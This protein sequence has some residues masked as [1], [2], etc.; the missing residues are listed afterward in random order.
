MAAARPAIA[1]A[2]AQ[3]AFVH[4]SAPRDADRWFAGYGLSD[5]ARV[6]DPDKGLYRRF[7]LHEAP[8]GQLAHPRVWWPWLRTAILGRRGFGLAGPNWRQLTGVF[9]LHQGRVTSAVRHADSAA[10]PDYVA[11]VRGV[12]PDTTIR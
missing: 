7:G 5:I 6:A 3:V 9:V 12:Q 8:L 11:L 4:M 2:G 1:A 10:R